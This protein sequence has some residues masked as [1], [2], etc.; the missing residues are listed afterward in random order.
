MAAES[1]R[2]AT[3]VIP[4]PDHARNPRKKSTA[5]SATSKRTAAIRRGSLAFG[6]GWLVVTILI[7]GLGVSYATIYHSNMPAPSLPTPGAVLRSEL[8][9]LIALALVGLPVWLT[10]GWGWARRRSAAA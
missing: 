9:A 3:P 4:M 10:L 2:W 1:C 7:L 6:L 5:R 8:G